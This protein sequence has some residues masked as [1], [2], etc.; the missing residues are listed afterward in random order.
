MLPFTRR[1][2]LAL[3]LLIF[4]T[5]CR[6]GP[7][8]QPEPSASIKPSL[9]P[10]AEVSTIQPSPAPTSLENTLAVTPV[11]YT[12]LCSPLEGQSL[13]NLGKPELLKNPFQAPRPG[14]DGGHH[15]ADFAYWTCPDGSAMLGLEVHAVLDGVV[16]GVVENR[17]PYGNAI[18]I[19]TPLEQ[20]DPAWAARLPSNAYDPATPLQPPLSLTCPAYAY[21]PSP[22]PVSLYLLYAHLNQPAALTPGSPVACGETIGAVGTSGKSVNPHLHLETRLGP[23][24]FTFASLAHYDTSATQDEI[25]Q[26]CLWRLSGAFQPFDPML[27][28][29]ITISP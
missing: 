7:L 26:Y 6:A 2:R 3:I 27:L 20:L 13:G 12:R 25:R 29:G 14:D 10:P 21:I 9:T 19:E 18:I 17:M 22:G 15:G 16:A 4:V 1:S 28:L 5:G 24:G 23:A 11:A 8:P